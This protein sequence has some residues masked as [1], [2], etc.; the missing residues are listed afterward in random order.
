MLVQGL[1]L[2][3]QHLKVLGCLAEVIADLSP[4]LVQLILDVAG[5]RCFAVALEVCD[6]KT[7]ADAEAQ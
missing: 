2:L 1:V 7:Q 6:Q 4:I 3:A 5:F